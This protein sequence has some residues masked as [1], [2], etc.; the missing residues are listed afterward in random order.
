MAKTKV[1]HCVGCTRRY[2]VST[3]LYGQTHC[4]R[5]SHVDRRKN[6]VCITP[7]CGHDID[8]SQNCSYRCD[9]I[10]FNITAYAHTVRGVC[11]KPTFSTLLSPSLSVSHTLSSALS[12]PLRTHTAHAHSR[13]IIHSVAEAEPNKRII[14]IPFIDYS[15]SLGQL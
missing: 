15:I 2:T 13:H 10:M 8:Q 11:I 14:I 4:T 12:P 6:S 1:R 5:N 9:Y 3:I 7:Q